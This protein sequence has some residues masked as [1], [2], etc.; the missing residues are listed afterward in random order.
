M[1]HKCTVC[2]GAAPQRCSGC[3]IV[4]YCSATCQRTHWLVH[5]NSCLSKIGVQAL[6]TG[7]TNIVVATTASPTAVSHA[8]ANTSLISLAHDELKA[9]KDAVERA[10]A[11]G[12][13]CFVNIELVLC[14]PGERPPNPSLRVKI[15]RTGVE[16]TDRAQE[17]ANAAGSSVLMKYC[18]D[19]DPS[20]AVPCIIWC[21]EPWSCYTFL[22]A[23]P[24]KLAEYTQKNK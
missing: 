11:E 18:S 17:I 22:P 6:I 2:G 1:S 4:Y 21:R 5:K 12:K 16:T 24:W 3:K 20:I 15:A 19:Y 7:Q 23:Q 9:S 13:R 14:E 8:T 10:H